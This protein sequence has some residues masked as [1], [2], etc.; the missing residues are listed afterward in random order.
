MKTHPFTPRKELITALAS[1]LICSAVLLPWLSAAAQDD[2]PT[3]WPD[4]LETPLP[5]K[6]SNPSTAW[7]PPL[8]AA[9]LALGPYDHFYFTR[10]LSADTVNWP[11]SSYRYGDTNFD[12]NKPHTGVDIVVD[13]DTP[14]MAAGDGTVIWS[15]Y[16]LFMGGKDR[17]DPYGLSVA[18]QHDFGY[19]GEPLISVYAHLN[20]SYVVKGQHV[21]RGEI[22]ALSGNTGLSTAPH[23][24][25]EI[26]K[27]EN[28]FYNS[29]NPELWTT[30]PQGWGLLVGELKTT[31]GAPLYEQKV[32]LMNEETG[33][34]RWA[35][36]YGSY[37]LINRDPYY[38]EN[39]IFG[40]LPAGKYLITIP[41]VG[42]TFRAEVNVYPGGISYFSFQGFDGIS[43]APPQVEA[44]ANLPTPEEN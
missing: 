25:F 8:Y 36:S 37:R 23:L 29:F 5:E 40:D 34:T 41:Y 9:P 38:Q 17:N 21:A 4:P 7:R 24:H 31:L 10:P 26:R 32:H 33:E 44:P 27:G 1:L 2:A 16:G 30:P 14:V 3:P 35:K 18:I 42:Q 28:Q 43:L 22:I 11:L 19:Y 6:V 13:E 12:R 15:E 39:I 20:T